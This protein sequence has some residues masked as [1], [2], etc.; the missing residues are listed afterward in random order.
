MKKLLALALTM[1]MAFT[2]AACSNNN[3]STQKEKTTTS[4]ENT[5]KETEEAG[6]SNTENNNKTQLDTTNRNILV[7]YFSFSGNTKVIADQIHEKVGGDIFEIKTEDAYPTDYDAVV[8]Q[9]KKEQEENYRPKLAT[10]ALN[11][12]SYDVIYVGY[13]NWWGT[14]PMAVFSFLEQYNFSGKTI[15]PF[16]THDGSALGKSV[17]DIKKTCPQATILDGLEIRGKSVKSENKEVSEWL[18]KL[19]MIN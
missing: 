6:T 15:I 7:A 14:M 1:M 19:G 11:M 3:N 12:D 8:D 10:K 13:P 5:Q 16:C 17:E 4:N 2:L 18:N 9:A